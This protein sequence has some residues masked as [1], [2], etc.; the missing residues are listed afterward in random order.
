MEHC[1][2]D[3]GGRESQVCVRGSDGQIV[4]ERRCR[5]A[6]LAAYLAG[7]P[8]S[9]VVVETCS[10]AFAIADAALAVGHEVRVVP[11][12]LVRSLGVGARRLK[13][14]RRD[15]QVLSE[16]SCRIDL[17]SVHVPS[18]QA[19]QRKTMCGM[20]EA[21]VGARTKLLNTVRGWLRSTASSPI[22]AWCPART[23]AQNANDEPA[24]PRP[25]HPRCA[26]VW[27]KPP[28]RRA[29]RDE[30]I[31]CSAGRT[32]LRSGVVNGS[33]SWRSR[34]SWRGS[35]TRSGETGRCTRRADPA[36]PDRATY[37]ACLGS[38]VQGR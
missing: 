30:K 27:C 5:T 20:R 14:D 6:A 24:S 37:G 10:E 29:G 12:T 34:A 35:C 11:S 8:P 2:I 21:L 17:P 3:L 18:Q 36:P 19:R 22:S 33:L 4:E 38:A 16:V 7:R 13:T 15:A 26:G 25:V 28:G 9:R 31:P 1:A 23:Q 32:K